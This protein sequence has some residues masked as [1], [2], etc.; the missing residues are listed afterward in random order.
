MSGSIQSTRACGC[1]LRE[2]SD[3][4]LGDPQD[5]VVE[6]DLRTDG[7][8]HCVCKPHVD[9]PDPARHSFGCATRGRNLVD[10]IG[11]GL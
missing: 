4:I 2:L 5:S 7:V 6:V 10:V 3:A 9:D 1:D 8:E 11:G